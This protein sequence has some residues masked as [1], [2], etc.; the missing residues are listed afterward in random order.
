MEYN[1]TSLIRTNWKQT[2]VRISESAN[3]NMFRE[4]IK[5]TSRVF[6]RKCNFI[7]K[8]YIAWNKINLLVIKCKK[9]V[10]LDISLKHILGS[11][12]T[13]YYWDRVYKMNFSRP[14]RFTP[15]EKIA[16]Y[17]LDRKPGGPQNWSGRR[18][19]E[20]ILA[21]TGTRTPTPRPYSP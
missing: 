8:T 21:P 4:V 17:P 6:F 12:H 5:W 3:E 15:G 2:L 1:N 10:N 19:E 7:L 13:Y 18:G 11:L 20:K 9:N 14:G 16:R